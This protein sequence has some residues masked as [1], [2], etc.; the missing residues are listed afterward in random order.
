[1]AMHA[2]FTRCLRTTPL[3]LFRQQI[4]KQQQQLSWSSKTIRAYSTNP[5][6]GNNAPDKPVEKD[7]SANSNNSETAPTT[8]TTTSSANPNTVINEILTE[9]ARRKEKFRQNDKQYNRL[10]D[11]LNLGSPRPAPASVSGEN[12]PSAPPPESE[13]KLSASMKGLGDEMQKLAQKTPEKS[14]ER[15]FTKYPTSASPLKSM[16]NNNPTMTTPKTRSMIKTVPMKLGPKLGRQIMVQNDRGMDCAS[17]IR[18]LEVS[19]RSND[20]RRQEANQRFHVRRGQARKNLR[21]RRWRK[22]FKFSF[23]ETVKRIDR[24]RD[25]GW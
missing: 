25:Q 1:M 19:C 4:P 21:I 18:S 5:S 24:M 22:L 3:S 14:P 23:L 11:H 8:S 9:D 12:K 6:Q 2:T 20:L 7:T 13:T 10:M 17:A 16:A 15:D